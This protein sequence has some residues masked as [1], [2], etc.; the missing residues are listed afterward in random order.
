MIKKI[1][2]LPYP[3]GALKWEWEVAALLNKDVWEVFGA[4]VELRKTR[5]LA[6]TGRMVDSNRGELSMRDKNVSYRNGYNNNFMFQNYWHAWAYLQQL[7]AKAEKQV[8]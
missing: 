8:A 2:L 4:T 5:L 3:M 6:I 1:D 7:K